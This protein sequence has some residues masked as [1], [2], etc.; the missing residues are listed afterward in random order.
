MTELYKKNDLDFISAGITIEEVDALKEEN[1][2]LIERLNRINACLAVEQA[3]N[4]YKEAKQRRVTHS[5]V[6]EPFFSFKE[7][8]LTGQNLNE[9]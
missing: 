5:Y 8:K 7:L 9:E 6:T 3:R 1:K 4:A 2:R